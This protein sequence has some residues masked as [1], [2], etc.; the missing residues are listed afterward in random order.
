MFF[1]IIYL[2]STGWC[3]C[4]CGTCRLPLPAATFLHPQRLCHE[5]GVHWGTDAR[6]SGAGRTGLPGASRRHNKVHRGRQGT[7]NG[8]CR[9]RR[10]GNDITIALWLRCSTF[11]NNTKYFPCQAWLHVLSPKIIVYKKRISKNRRNNCE[12]PWIT[13]H[14]VSLF[15]LNGKSQHHFGIT[16][17][18]YEV[19]GM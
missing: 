4:L 16:F 13:F 17:H 9:R 1:S 2:Y 7:G 5:R 12:L 6:V 15:F 19:I 8:C 10:N 18:E 11:Q 3:L 14:V